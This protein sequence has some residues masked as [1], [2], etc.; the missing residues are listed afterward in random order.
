MTSSG[1]EPLTFRLVVKCLN[2]PRHQL[3][4]HILHRLKEFQGTCR[5]KSSLFGGEFVDWLISYWHAKNCANRWQYGA[6]AVG[7]VLVQYSRASASWTVVTS[8]RYIVTV[9]GLTCSCVLC[10]PLSSI[11]F[12][13]F[14]PVWLDF[15]VDCTCDKWG[16]MQS[17]T[18]S[19]SAL[20]L[21]EG[22]YVL[23]A[24]GRTNKGL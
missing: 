14:R 5:N 23:P 21:R 17:D 22:P 20:G 2:Q 15:A 3:P 18:P 19:D 24:I 12:C 4:L 10:V 7:L 6:S 8:Y 13:F 11:I 16:L 9:T 1:I